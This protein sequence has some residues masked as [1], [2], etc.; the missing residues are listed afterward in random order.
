[1]R[2]RAAILQTLRLL[3]RFPRIGR[4][5]TVEGVRKIVTRRY[6]YIVYYSVDDGAREIIIHTIQ[7][8]S[9][10]REYTDL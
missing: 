10:R 7:H 3:T 6:P 8:A 4:A 5:Q 9:R 1:M 2:V